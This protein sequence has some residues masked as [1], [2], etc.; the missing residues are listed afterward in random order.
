VI[1]FLSGIWCHLKERGLLVDYCT[2]RS[3]CAALGGFHCIARKKKKRVL[4]LFAVTA[5]S[6]AAARPPLAPVCPNGIQ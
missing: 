5:T 6:K 3:K 2:A 4:S 1:L